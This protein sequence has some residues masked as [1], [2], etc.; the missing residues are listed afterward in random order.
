MP[1]ERVR[2]E[3]RALVPKPE[4]KERDQGQSSGPQFGAAMVLSLQQ[5][6][7]NHAVQRLLAREATHTGYEAMTLAG[8]AIQRQSKDESP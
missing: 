6:V 5:S 1:R 3:T 4:V 2:K 8:G 7:G